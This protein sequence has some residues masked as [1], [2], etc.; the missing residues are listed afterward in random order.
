MAAFRRFYQAYAAG[1]RGGGYTQRVHG[2]RPDPGRALAAALGL[3]LGFAFVE[4]AAGVLAGSLALLSDAGHMLIDSAG[5]LLA[6]A[7]TVVSRRPA[8]MRRSYGYARAEVLVVPLHVLLMLGIAGFI[9]YEAVQR[10]GEPVEVLGWPVLLVGVVGLGVNLVVVRLL[11]EHSDLNLN[12]RGALLEVIADT[13]GSVAVI[14]SGA[15]IAATGWS[16]VDIVAS[17]AIAALVLPRAG[18]LLR[19]AVEILL[20][21][22]PGH[23]SLRRIEEDARR[24]PGVLALHDLHVWS[25]APHFVALSAHVEVSSMEGC[26]RVI[27]GLARMLRQEHGIAHVTLQPE[28]REVHEAVECCALPDSDGILAHLHGEASHL[29]VVRKEG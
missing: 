9:V 28:T 17:L 27:A 16:A 5:L 29:P 4:A 14:V 25:L 19:Q 2:V 15:M 3:T 1:D 13:L 18:S 8:D 12:A 22:A 7:A 11:L 24:I 6:L 21:G 20:E 23:L 10:I 26:E